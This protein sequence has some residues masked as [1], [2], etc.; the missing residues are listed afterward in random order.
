VSKSLI[1][2][3]FTT[4]DVAALGHGPGMIFD[5]EDSIRRSRTETARYEFK[6]GLLRLDDSRQQDPHY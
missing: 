3:Q 5:F 1:R 4:A 6:Q 2:D